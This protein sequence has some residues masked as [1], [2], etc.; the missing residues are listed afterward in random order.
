LGPIA[1]A[2][3]RFYHL[4]MSFNPLDHPLAWADPLML[5]TNSD[6]VGHIPFVMSLVDLL[7]PGTLVELGTHTG[8]SYCAFC[9]AVRHCQLPTRCFAV[10]TWKGDVSIG[11]YDGDAMYDDLRK[12]H[13]PNFGSFSKLMR[14]DFDSALGQFGDAS[15]DLLHI[16]GCHTYEAVRHD[17]ES[18]LPKLS[19]RGVI[20][21]HDTTEHREGFG[22]WKLWDEVSSQYPSINFPHCHGL[23]MLLVGSH[24]QPAV[25]QFMERAAKESAQVARFF[26]FM[27][28]RIETLQMMHYMLVFAWEAQATLNQW[29][30]AHGMPIDEPRSAFQSAQSQPLAFLYKLKVNT[31]QVLGKAR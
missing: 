28:R 1:C 14:M 18:W 13:D 5:S 23:G 3:A 30:T 15:I 21:F 17:F 6:F 4:A 19:D 25:V 31:Q 9:Q 27:G 26:A 16:D 22:V 24:P 11:A 8:N 20:L 10:D 2:I 12:Y 7:R 29:C